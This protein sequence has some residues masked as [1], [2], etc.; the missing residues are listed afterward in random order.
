MPKTKCHTCGRH[1][2][3]CPKCNNRTYCEFCNTC[4]LHGQGDPT[5]EM[6]AK[7]REK[8]GRL[9]VVEVT[10]LTR[11]GWTETFT[12]RVK[13]KGLAGA[14]WGGVRQAR[15]ENLK[16]RTHVGQARVMAVPA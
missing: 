9:F 16:P 13:A 15:R 11:R 7:P 4:N 14:I 5:P 2:Q 12:V 6:I 8:T 1:C 10:F 3:R